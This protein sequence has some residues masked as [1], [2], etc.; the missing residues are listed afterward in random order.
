MNVIVVGASGFG[1]E[2]LQY[3]H[4]AYRNDPAVRIKGFLD[5]DRAKIDS[6]RETTGIEIVGDM[7]TYAIE[8]EDRFIISL[9]DPGLRRTLAGRLVRRGAKFISVVHPTAYLAPTA[10]IGEGCIIGP[11][12]MV[13]S[14]AH[15]EHHVLL[16]LYSAVGHDACVAAFCVFSPYSVANGGS[17]LEEGI[18]LG[19]HAAVTPNVRVGA[20]SKIAA[21]A[22]VYR[23]VPT[24]SLATGNPSK[25]FPI[26][27][28][29]PSEQ[30]SSPVRAPLPQNDL[31]AGGGR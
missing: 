17:R 27:E 28:D 12:A 20:G 15:L 5:D 11:F 7:D 2:L 1:R 22:V 16:N 21:G 18:F 24:R 4:D 19:T 10:R 13:G 9:G 25:A 6:I 8:K 26:D 30:F 14:Y 29:A 23:D 3:I 31:T